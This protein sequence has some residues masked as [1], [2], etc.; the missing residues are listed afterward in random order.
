MK[1][2][3]LIITAIFFSSQAIAATSFSLYGLTCEFEA[4]P[5][6]VETTAPRFSWKCNRPERGYVQSAYQIMAYEAGKVIWDSGK[7]K[8]GNSVLIPY[9]GQTLKDRRSNL[10]G[11]TNGRFAHGTRRAGLRNGAKFSDS[12]WASFPKA[13]GKERNG[14]PWRTTGLKNIYSLAI[15]A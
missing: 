11:I 2:I 8:S 6:G 3:C 10:S 7:V 15:M 12:Q 1:H 5:A 4:N 9:S 14:L 13:T